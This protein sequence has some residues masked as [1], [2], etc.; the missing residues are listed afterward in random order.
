MPSQRVLLKISGEAFMGSQ[1]FGVSHDAALIVANRIYDLQKRDISVG[2]VLGGGN[3]FRGIQNGPSLQ[4]DRSRADQLGMMATLMN[5]VILQQALER[6]GGEGR[7]LSALECP[8]VAESFQWEKAISYLNKGKI[9]IFVGGT[10]HPFFTTDTCAALRACEI[11]ADILLKATTKVDGIYDSDPRKNA[12][13]KKFTTLSF[14]DILEKR[15]GIMDLSAIAMCME[16]RIPIRVF[17]FFEGSLFD[18]LE[19]PSFGTLVTHLE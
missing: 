8:K 3:I 1:S 14:Q 2:V 9:V 7:L 5:G 19:N 16:A 6:V 15:L 17:N 10:G 18:A 12:G 4:L 11:H 13:A